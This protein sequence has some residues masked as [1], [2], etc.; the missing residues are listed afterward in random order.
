MMRQQSPV[1]SVT[2]NFVFADP[3]LGSEA[4]ISP[5]SAERLE[6]EQLFHNMEIIGNSWID[7]NIIYQLS[8]LYNWNIFSDSMK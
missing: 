6:H 5:L 7:N 2:H 4:D 3:D 8:L 1:S